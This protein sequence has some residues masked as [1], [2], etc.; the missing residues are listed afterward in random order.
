MYL[1]HTISSYGI[2]RAILDQDLNCQIDI[3]QRQKKPAY[4]DVLA[5]GEQESVQL[6]YT[7]MRFG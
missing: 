5:I 1:L 4:K 7:H 2:L 3:K 6:A